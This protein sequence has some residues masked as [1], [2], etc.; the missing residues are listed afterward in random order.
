M[1]HRPPH[2]LIVEDDEA[3]REALLDT[4][5]MAGLEAGAAADG[6]AA[7]QQLAAHRFDLVISDIQMQPMDGHA[8]LREIRKFD[9][10]LPVVL[11]TAHESI[12]SAVAALRDGATDY[13]VKP[14]E[15]EVLLGRIDSWVPAPPAAVLDD[16]VSIDPASRQM[17]ELARRVA[18]SDASVM[19]TGESGVGKEVVFRT[20]HQY[21]SRAAHTAVAINCAAIPDNMLEAVLFGY[22]KGAFTGAYKACPGK[23]EQAQASSLL[24]DEISEMPLTL[25]AKLLRVLQERQV[26]RLGA[27][28]LIDLDVR[29]VATSNRDL[30]EEVAAGRFR[31]DLYYRLNVMPI[32]VPP[33]RERRADIVPL[34]RALVQ[35]AATRGQGSAPAL[36]AAAARRLTEYDW[37]GNVRELDNVMQRALILH[38]GLSIEAHDL[39][40]ES[41]AVAPRSAP[42]S[43]FSQPEEGEDTLGGDLKDH[44]RR[45]ILGALSEGGGSRKFA[46]EKLGISPRT[47]RYKIARMRDQGIT[48][49]GA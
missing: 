7:L 18:Q 19:I 37:P 48:V 2:L 36:A 33:L 39:L 5:S 28:R 15:A 34:A 8:L 46:A 23:F 14:F 35:R 10:D 38:Q 22:E 41:M 29:I 42:D 16:T 30:R 25:Q 4:A 44:E 45:L 11:M 1:T 20:I 9:R 21:S 49:P 3:L 17:F 12:A 31:E 32:H 40:F 43:T 27:Q 6:T 26:E 24:L 13:L 47:L